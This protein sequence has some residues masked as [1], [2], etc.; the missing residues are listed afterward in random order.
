MILPANHL[1]VIVDRDVGSVAAVVGAKVAVWGT[2]PFIKAILQRKVLWSVAKMPVVRNKVLSH[3]VR[4]MRLTNHTQFM[5][6]LVH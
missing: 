2:K 6:A 4:S 1:R 3:T 5:H